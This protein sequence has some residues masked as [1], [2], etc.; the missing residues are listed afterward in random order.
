[1]DTIDACFKIGQVLRI[2]A[3]A[4]TYAGVKDKRAK[5]SQWCCVR[6][7]APSKLLSNA[8]RIRNLKVGNITFKDH[9]LKIGQLSGNFFRIALRNVQAEDGLINASINHV[10]EH[11]FINYYGLQRF[12]NDKEAP[13]FTIGIKLIK[14]EWKE[15]SLY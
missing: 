14:G 10:K 13:T 12:G 11:G 9:C 8:G 6:K 3:S 5:T 7:F 2:S 15:V 4:I 1:M